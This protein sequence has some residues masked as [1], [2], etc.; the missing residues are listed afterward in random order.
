MVSSWKFLLNHSNDIVHNF[1][2]VS[3]THAYHDHICK[4]Y[5]LHH[6]HH[7]CYVD[8]MG[9]FPESSGVPPVIIHGHDVFHYKPTSELGVPPWLW[10]QPFIVSIPWYPPYN[11]MVNPDISWFIPIG[12]KKIPLSPPIPK[13]PRKYLM[14]IS[15]YLWFFVMVNPIFLKPLTI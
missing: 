4:M 15:H 1:Y 6:V 2:D 8:H 13:H 9:G 12:L 5:D 3:K 14:L 7:T 11:P 10:N